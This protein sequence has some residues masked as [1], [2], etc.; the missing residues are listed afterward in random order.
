MNKGDVSPI[1]E[2]REG[3]TLLRCVDII[4]AQAPSLERARRLV[5]LRLTEER[6]PP[7]WAA[8]VSRL[9]AELDPVYPKGDARRGP[10]VAAVATY[11]DGRGRSRVTRED[12]LLYVSDRGV[13]RADSLRPLL[14]ERVRQEGFLKEAERRGLLTQKDD[15]VFFEWK[16]REMRAR[17]VERAEVE[18]LVPPP[19]EAEMRAAYA[20][21]AKPLVEP[22]R[23]TLRALKIALK[24]DRPLS[25]YEEARKVGERVAAGSMRFEDAAAA[26]RAH[27]ELVEL[28]SLTADEVWL[29]GRN[30]DAAVQAT[31]VGGTSRLVQEGRTLWILNVAARTPERPL[32]F[33]E[34][35]PQVHDG[36][37]RAARRRAVAEFRRRL[38]E[39]QAVALAP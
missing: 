27:A 17:A 24:R 9:D 28:G 1:I 34:A 21:R 25:Y 18:A 13:V 32:S 11:R 19:T 38:L 33:E 36:L 20:S 31:P 23:V 12:F 16:E 4:E 15:D 14:L 35:R 39:E 26:L 29:M 6:F 30:V 2:T 22:A 3:L 37:W 5:S 8:L 10:P 7:A